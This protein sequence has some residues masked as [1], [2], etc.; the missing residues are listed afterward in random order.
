MAGPTDETKAFLLSV[1]RS[2]WS[3]SFVAVLK[4]RGKLDHFGFNLPGGS[5]V[6]S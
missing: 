1:G 2:R 3:R 5:G 4:N 6:Q